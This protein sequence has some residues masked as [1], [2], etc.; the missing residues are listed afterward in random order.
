MTYYVYILQ[1]EKDD[2][3][4]IGQTQDL[5]LRLAMHNSGRS[6]YTRAKGPWKLYASR[7]LGNRSE[8]VKMERKLKNLGSKDRIMHFLQSNNFQMY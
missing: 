4:Y 5:N 1:S 8:A 2:G 3:F 6:K 7:E